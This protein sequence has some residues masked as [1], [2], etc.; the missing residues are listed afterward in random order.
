MRPTLARL[1]LAFLVVAIPA[2]LAGAASCD[3][4]S[5]T[6]EMEQCLRDELTD[7]RETLHEY[8]AEVRRLHAGGTPEEAAVLAAFEDAERAWE[9]FVS[10]D[11]AA[12]ST[13]YGEGS[14]R[15]V[16]GLAVELAHVEA[17]T[18]A[19]WERYL[20]GAATDLPEPAPSPAA[21]SSRQS[22]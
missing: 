10:A 8:R 1:A 16:A 19:L 5:T 21:D 6:L 14:L 17:R 15:Q 12:E 18:K 9:S 20:R 13:S 2:S 4:V 3:A 11:R 22:R 7:R